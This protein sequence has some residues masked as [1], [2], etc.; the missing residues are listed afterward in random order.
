[1]TLD[2]HGDTLYITTLHLPTARIF[3]SQLQEF[4]FITLLQ[5]KLLLSFT[6]LLN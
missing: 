2:T 3:I 6:P 5:I 1:M 4:D